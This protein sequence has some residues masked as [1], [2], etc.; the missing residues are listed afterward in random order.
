MNKE[1]LLYALEAM[2]EHNIDFY[3]FSETNITKRQAEIWQKQLGFHSYF[4]YSQQE[5]KGQGVGIII[6]ADYNIFV[7]KAVADK[8]GRLIY[9]DLYFSQN[10]KLRLIQVWYYSLFRMLESKHY[11]DTLPLFNDNDED[12]ITYMPSDLNKQPAR[13]DYIWASLPTISKCLDTLVIENVY[14]KTDHKTVTLSIDTAALIGQKTAKTNKKKKK[15][16]RTVFAYDE[17]DK[18]DHDD[19]K[20]N[21]FKKELDERID[22][23][24]LKNY[25]KAVKEKIKNRE[26]VKNKIKTTPEQKLS[27]YYDL[28]YIINRIQEIR[29]LIRKLRNVPELEMIDRWTCLQVTISKLKDKYEI[30]TSHNPLTF[31][32][33]FH[34][35][36]YLKELN[37]ICKHLRHVFKI[38]LHIL[39]QEQIISHIKKRCVNYKDD[40]A[41][42]ITSITEKEMAHISIEKIYKKD[43]NGNESLITD[44][45]D[46]LRETIHHFQTIAG[47]N[48][49]IYS[50]IMNLPSKDKWLDIIRNTPNGK[51]AGPSGICNEMLKHLSDDCHDVLYCLI[52]KI[53]EFGNLPKQWKQATV[54]PIAKP[55]P[56]NCKLSNS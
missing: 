44:E 4:S 36:L 52:C 47:V 40:Q 1:K 29:S 20:W 17:M 2:N 38:E 6:R 33:N 35:T 12:I 32:N 25:Y 3:G 30:F 19:F 24:D 8:N 14:F 26:V 51:A 21:N 48:D 7:H 15:I 42:M 34:F 9:I 5:G 39:E 23:L 43:H 11:L 31:N 46:V 10:K 45:S 50:D 41:K 54:F 13:L 53:I 28:R 27:I 55:K 18:K 49:D 16:T 22:Q 37:E 56:F